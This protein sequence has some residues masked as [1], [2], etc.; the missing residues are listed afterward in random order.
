MANTSL[1][2]V[3]EGAGLVGGFRTDANRHYCVLWGPDGAATDIVIDG[4]ESAILGSDTPLRGVPPAGCRSGDASG[5]AAV[6]WP[7]TLKRC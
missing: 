5:G 3:S 4:R 2:V 6:L 1:Q 7:K